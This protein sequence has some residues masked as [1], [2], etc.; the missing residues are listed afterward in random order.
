MNGWK[1][2]KT[3][4]IPAI[5]AA[6]WYQFGHYDASADTET[7]SLQTAEIVENLQAIQVK[8]ATAAEAEA[9]KVKELCLRGL[10]KDVAECAKV[11]VDARPILRRQQ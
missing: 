2:G 6:A 5:I 9:S 10:L 7:R 4:T 1:I 11:G 8:Q 3:L